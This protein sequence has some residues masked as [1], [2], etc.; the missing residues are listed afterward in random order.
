MKRLILVTSPPASG[1]TYVS[2]KLAERLDHVVY[3]DKDT[4]IPLS[5]KIFE[6]A[7][8]AYNRSSPFFEK[9]IR[10]AEYETIVALALEALDYDDTV[11]INAPF[12]REVRDGAYMGNLRRLLAEKGSRLTVIWVKTDVEVVKRRMEARNSERD[13][14]KLDH[15][16]KYIATCDFSIPKVLD[17]PDTE[18]DLLIFNNSNDIEFHESMAR[19][20]AL[21]ETR[22]KI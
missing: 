5:K 12:S 13:K 21:L 6:V 16:E 8:E 20:T 19:I 9:Y 22:E 14:W 4:L 17:L 1:K 7:N 10:D 2:K 18:D 15:W 11:L 3:L